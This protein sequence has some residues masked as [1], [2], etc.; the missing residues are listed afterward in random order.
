[1][2]DNNPQKIVAK[3]V[4]GAYITPETSRSEAENSPNP[5]HD[6]YEE[7][8]QSYDRIISWLLDKVECKRDSGRQLRFIL[9]SQYQGSLKQAVK[10]NEKLKYE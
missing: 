4:R 3:I 8:N 2:R 5:V 9:A 7:T 1:M 6:S 10:R